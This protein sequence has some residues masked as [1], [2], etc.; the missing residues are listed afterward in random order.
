M[1]LLQAQGPYVRP[2]LHQHGQSV[3]WCREGF[4]WPDRDASLGQTL[5]HA[6][7]AY[8]VQA[9][10]PMLAVEVLAPQPGERVLDLCAAPGGKTTQ[11]AAHMQN[12]GLATGQ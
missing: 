9:K 8:Y 7:G 4:A 12:S 5:E 3:P 11:I 6:L 1:N 2:H 10:A